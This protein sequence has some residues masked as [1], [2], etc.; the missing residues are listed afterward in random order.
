MEKS[1]G[2]IRIHTPEIWVQMCSS[3]FTQKHPQKM[4]MTSAAIPLFDHGQVG[5]YFTFMPSGKMSDCIQVN[6]GELLVFLVQFSLFTC[7]YLFSMFR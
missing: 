3:N 5:V 7:S 4:T 2:Q 1:E 6:A